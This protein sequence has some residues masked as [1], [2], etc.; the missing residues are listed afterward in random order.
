MTELSSLPAFISQTE[1][2]PPETTHLEHKAT[3][4]DTTSTWGTKLLSL[5]KEKM[6]QVGQFFQKV[7]ENA[8]CT[9]HMLAMRQ[10]L[11][12]VKKLSTLLFKKLGDEW[13]D[14]SKKLS[15]NRIIRKL[16]DSI[17]I[18]LKCDLRFVRQSD[19]PLVKEKFL[20]DKEKVLENYTGFRSSLKQ[21]PPEDAI[22]RCIQLLLAIAKMEFPPDKYDIRN[23]MVAEVLTKHIATFPLTENIKLPVPC[24]DRQGQPIVINYRMALRLSLGTSNVPAYI[25]VPIE[26]STINDFP[27]LLIFRGTRLKINDHADM[28][29]M[30]ENLNN[31][32][33][34]K[35]IYEDFKPSLELL[36]K[37]WTNIYQTPPLFRVLGYSQGGVI[38]QR[39]CVDFHS[40]L[41]KHA[42]NASIFF[43]S[44][45]VEIDYIKYWNALTIMEK[46][47]VLNY[48]ITR[49]LVSKR[50]SKFIGDVYEIEP[51][52]EESFL[53]AHLGAKSIT[54]KLGLYLIN[55][56]KEAVSYSRQLVNQ[57]MSSASIEHLYLIASK[58]L[59]KFEPKRKVKATACI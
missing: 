57:V 56:D 11:R 36:L 30:I 58:G 23:A 24:F 39:T 49:D 51:L 9:N 26:D 47:C 4:L 41:D 19:T 31:I 8:N 50:G 3:Q 35:G 33:P 59:S 1:P 43:N 6:D 32:G 21:L 17:E 53:E 15:E 48:L 54:P 38:G 12:H 14:T 37:N 40:Y 7:A 44:P 42:L 27:S 18:L 2:N 46:P 25:L 52:V 55:N 16:K 34:A 20:Q 45:A 10:S 29:C 13:K 28:R 22:A 5:V